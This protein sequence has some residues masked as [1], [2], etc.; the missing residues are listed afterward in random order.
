MVTHDQLNKPN[1]LAA[2]AAVKRYKALIA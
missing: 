2:V 1:S